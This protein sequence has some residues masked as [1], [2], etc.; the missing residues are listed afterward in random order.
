MS[1]IK[2]A[3]TAA[4]GAAAVADALGISRISIYEWIYKG[5]VPEPRVLRLAELTNWKITPHQLAP[6][7]YPNPRDGLPV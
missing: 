5:R 4:G 6:A 1:L 3:V 2:D 7:L